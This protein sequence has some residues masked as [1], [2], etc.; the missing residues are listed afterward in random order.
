[1]APGKRSREGRV[2][3]PL[4]LGGLGPAGVDPARL[5][6]L[7]EGHDAVVRRQDD[8]R[9][10]GSDPAVDLLEEPPEED[11]Q[12]QD[13]VHQLLAVRPVR[14]SDDV[15]S[16]EADGHEVGGLASPE[17]VGVHRGEGRVQD[18]LVGRRRPAQVVV[19]VPRGRR[20]VDRVREDGV[21]AVELPLDG[22][23]AGVFLVE[24]RV[25]EETR[26]GTS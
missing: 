17:V 18:H 4:E 8:E 10:A 15:G 23:G 26:P 7:D 21:L 19:V 14:V 16:R 6:H 20:A 2:H 13:L 11:V 24:R 12:A 1:M 9:A 3:R 5:Q 22:I 25:G